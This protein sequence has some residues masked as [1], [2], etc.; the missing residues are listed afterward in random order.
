MA[1]SEA[2]SGAV[3]EAEAA[4]LATLRSKLP[5]PN[6]ESD[7]TLL[8]FLRAR[9]GQVEAAFAQYCEAQSWREQ[10]DIERFR[11]MAPPRLDGSSPTSG[12][13]EVYPSI[14]LVE[15]LDEPGARFFYGLMICSGMH[16]ASGLLFISCV[17]VLSSDEERMCL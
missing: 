13:V 2:A 6:K 10:N 12:Q 5:G 7:E 1:S 9:K 4:N 8:R 15:P 14:R 11:Q 16:C 17:C 3:D